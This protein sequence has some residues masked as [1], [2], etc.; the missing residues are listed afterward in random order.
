MVFIMF[1]VFVGKELKSIAR[2]PKIIIAMF[3]VPLIIIIV[4]YAII[5]YG[6]QQQITQAIKERRRKGCTWLLLSCPEYQNVM[7]A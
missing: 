4:F 2:D 6:L 3:I 5:G 7:E 1:W